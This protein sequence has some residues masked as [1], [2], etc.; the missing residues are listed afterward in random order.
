M[1]RMKNPFFIITVIAMILLTGCQQEAKT[2]EQL[3]EQKTEIKEEINKAV[4]LIEEAFEA[5]ESS[6]F[7]EKADMAL[8]KVDEQLDRYHDLMDNSMERI[9]K[10]TRD[11]IIRI[12]QKTVEIDFRLALLEDNQVTTRAGAENNDTLDIRRTRPV[13]Y[14]FPVV[15]TPGN[16]PQG[17]LI[18]YGDEVREATIKNLQSLQNELE[19]FMEDS[20]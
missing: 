20:L 15:T 1:Q 10:D 8:N 9:Y 11:R 18:R 16:P 13:A 4:D 6:E 7:I 2:D 3:Q 5:D 14:Q 19:L 12:K 17:D